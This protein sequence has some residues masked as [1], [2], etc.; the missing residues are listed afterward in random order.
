M[1]S[2]RPLNRSPAERPGPHTSR[3]LRKREGGNA[4]PD[5]GSAFFSFLQRAASWRAG[6]LN[7]CKV[8]SHTHP[9]LLSHWVQTAF[10][11]STQQGFSLAP[12]LTQPSRGRLPALLISFFSPEAF[13]KVTGVLPQPTP[14]LTPQPPTPP[15][16][17]SDSHRGSD[18]RSGGGG[19]GGGVCWG[20]FLERQER[21]GRQTAKRQRGR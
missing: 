13:L 4:W 15:L 11:T 20:G 8:S 9:T 14:Q 16:L 18:P 10:V 19:G 21:C 17:M 6:P 7:R 3:D 5:L 2:A 1:D 12:V